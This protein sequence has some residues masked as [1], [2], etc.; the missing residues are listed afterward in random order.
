MAKKPVEKIEFTY[1]GTDR[2]GKKV[3]GE[4]YALNEALAKGELRKQGINPMRVKKK[5]Q[6]L[7]GGAA[8]IKPVDI[9]IFSRQMATMMK[10]GVPLVQSFDIIGMG[11]ENP[12]MQ[13]MIMGIKSEVEGGATFADSLKKFPILL[14]SNIKEE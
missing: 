7:F 12:A 4:I 9:A 2:K 11:H 1:Q 13:K 5:P 8:K 14:W 3:K 10:S 6:P